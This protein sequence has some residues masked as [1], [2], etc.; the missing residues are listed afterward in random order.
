MK[1]IYR[2]NEADIKILIRKYFGINEDKINFIYNLTFNERNEEEAPVL[3]VEA[4]ANE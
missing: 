3:T 4:I 1:V 2:F